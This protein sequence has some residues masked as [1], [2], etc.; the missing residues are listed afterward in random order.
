[1]VGLNFLFTASYTSWHIAVTKIYHLNGY[2]NSRRKS[3]HV[4]DN[5]TQFLNWR[6]VVNTCDATSRKY[7]VF[8]YI[9]L[10]F[11]PPIWYYR[12]MSANGVMANWH[13]FIFR[14]KRKSSGV[15]GLNM[16]FGLYYVIWNIELKNYNLSAFTTH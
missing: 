1:M 13:F 10:I 14:V 6:V 16:I 2:P 12:D 7:L 15:R 11:W 4:R 9:E 3:R 8:T 5:V